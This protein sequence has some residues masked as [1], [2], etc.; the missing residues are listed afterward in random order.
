MSTAAMVDAVLNDA[1][2]YGGDKEARDDDM[3]VVVA[4]L[5]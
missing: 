3:T 5:A 1:M 4:K 2:A